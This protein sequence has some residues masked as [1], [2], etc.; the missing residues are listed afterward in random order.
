M[1][2]VWL[3]GHDFLLEFL[4]DEDLAGAYDGPVD[5]GAVCADGPVCVHLCVNVDCA[6]DLAY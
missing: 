6:L 3:H 2:R 4:I 1:T 5:E